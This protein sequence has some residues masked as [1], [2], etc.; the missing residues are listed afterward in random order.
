MPTYVVE[1]SILGMEYQ[2]FLSGCDDGGGVAG[3]NHQVW[4]NGA[5][6]GMPSSQSFLEGLSSAAQVGMR[7]VGSRGIATI[8]T[9]TLQF[10]GSIAA[11]V[12]MRIP[13]LAVLG[14]IFVGV[15]KV[16][17]PWLDHRY[18]SA[19]W[20]RQRE[21]EANGGNYAAPTDDFD[22][23][24]GNA[25]RYFKQNKAQILRSLSGK[26]EHQSGDYG[27]YQDWEKWARQQ[28]EE[29]SQ[30]QQQQGGYTNQQQN[31]QYQRQQQTS[32]RQQR[33]SNKKPKKEYK[34]EFDP[35]DPYSVLGL[36]R[37]ATKSEVSGAFRREMLKHHPDVQAGASDA[38]KE[39]SQE[40]SKY[41]TEA[42]R[43]IKTEMKR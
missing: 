33:Q 14:S 12:A 36:R 3:A 18:A 10:L 8:L 15:R 43:K 28:Y 9:I 42:Y 41:I 23:I 11:R 40:R 4:G 21:R 39:R 22:D 27:W 2:A 32:G 34:F 16:I 35:N 1:Y 25:R 17:Y 5:T 29:S 24:R 13:P 6:E 31:Q 30:Q 7:T 20:E 19:E 26:S 37:G 38:E